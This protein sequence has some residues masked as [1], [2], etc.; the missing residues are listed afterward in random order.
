MRKRLQRLVQAATARLYAATHRQAPPTFVRVAYSLPR[1]VVLIT[2]RHGEQEDVWPIDWHTPL[3]ISPERYGICVY[4]GGY[5]AELLA[6]AKCFVVNFVPDS[7]EKAILT[8]GNTTGRNTDKFAAA[9]LLREN[10]ETIAAPRLSGCLGHLEC[11]VE[12]IEDFDDRWFVIGRV[13]HSALVA[14][15]SQLFHVSSDV[16]DQRS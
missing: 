16:T 6:A 4:R 14:P 12:R 11:E 10:A 8:C 5:G 1:R 9:G 3:S 7:W 15:G 2:V 13:T